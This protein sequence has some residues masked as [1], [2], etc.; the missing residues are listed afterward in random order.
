MITGTWTAAYLLLTAAAP[1]A[2]VPADV[3][4]FNRNK[5]EIPIKIAPGQQDKIR[6]LELHCSRNG[7]KTWE[8]VGTARPDQTAFPYTAPADGTYWFSVLIVD[9]KG[10]TEPRSPYGVPPG[11]KVLVD[12]EAPSV[13]IV[14][15]ERKGDLINVRW[16]AREEY[17]NLSTFRLEYK[18]ADGS[19]DWMAVPATQAL[20]GQASFRSAGPVAVRATVAD[21]AQNVGV[22]PEVKVAGAGVM[23]ASAQ[24]LEPPEGS[25]PLAPPGGPGA[26]AVAAQPPVAAPAPL[27]RGSGTVA[28]EI[29]PPPAREVPPSPTPAAPDASEGAGHNTVPSPLPPGSEGKTDSAANVVAASSSDSKKEPVVPPPPA[30]KDATPH[31]VNNPRVTLE[32]KVAR[33]GPSGVGAVDL[34]M[35]QDDGQSWQKVAAELGPAVPARPGE[36]ML[37]TLSLNLGQDGTYGFTLV[38]HSKAGLSRPAPR[39]SEA[40]QMRLELDTTAPVATLYKPVPNPAQRDALVLKWDAK[41]KNLGSRPITLE[42]AE[43]PQ[44]EWKP[45]GEKQLPNTGSYTWKV[46]E[47]I[48]AMVYLRLTVRDTAG[49]VAV[50]ASRTPVAIDLVEPEANFT[51]FVRAGAP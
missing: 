15:A 49:N 11:L 27:Q 7:G 8:L 28:G 17:P 18:P 25:T 10:K 1:A 5:F 29:K 14:S 50:A 4:P 21:M 51:G 36:P 44:A 41:D 6:S 19:G 30:D 31:P 39:A 23:T 24:T 26:P 46:P 22:S 42:W 34:Y 47:G 33:F 48:P 13:S 20:A 40:P 2:G 43:Q 38:V 16:E 45:I 3:E 37:R 32:Y 35:T 12:T 9:R